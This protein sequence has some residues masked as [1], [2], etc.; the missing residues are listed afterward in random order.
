MVYTDPDTGEFF[1]LVIDQ[2]LY[3]GDSLPASLISPFS[4]R[5]MVL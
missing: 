1:I 4:L 2:G 3:M 5:A